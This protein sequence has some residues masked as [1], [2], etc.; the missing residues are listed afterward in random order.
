MTMPPNPFRPGAGHPPPYLAG[1]EAE[2]RT[3]QR[4]LA[5]N[6]I[7]E[8]LVLSGLRGS[9]KTVLLESF[10][11]LATA[12]GWLWTGTDINESASIA[13]GNLATRL[14]ADLAIKTSS[15]VVAEKQSMAPGFTSA[16]E[17]L[18]QGLGFDELKQVFT[19]TPGLPLDKLKA[20]IEHGWE[21]LSRRDSGIR[22][23]IF[24]YDEA[25][26]LA[27]HAG[28][29]Q[30]PLSLLLDAFQS[31]QRKGLPLMLAL[32]G[33]PTLYPKLVD[34]RTYAERMFRSVFLESL[35]G[36]ETRDAILKPIENNDWIVLVEE[37]VGG[38]V[39]MSGGYPYFIQF[40]CREVYDAFTVRSDKGRG[41][42]VPVREIEEKLDTDFFSGRWSLATDRQRELLTI[43]ASLDHC[44]HE[45][46]ISEIVEKSKETP[47]RPFSASNTSQMLAVLATQGLLYRNRFGKYTF[48]LPMFGGF[49][50]RQMKRE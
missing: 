20:A 9:G 13:E 19:E 3:F 30:F 25:Q 18:R 28:K 42:K 35:S 37:T 38:I 1:R 34:S 47:M 44:G 23:V 12:S 27:D 10:K 43:I 49:I 17:T 8:N 5:Q 22:G 45:F 4:L 46:S 16:P 40:I 29:D 48:A 39:E 2:K 24:A 11:H 6:A 15:I 26:N 31:M 50:R 36:P 14:C 21:A 7:T 41:G 32:A 33:L